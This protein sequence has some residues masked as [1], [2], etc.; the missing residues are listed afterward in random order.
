M[1]VEIP[2]SKLSVELVLVELP[3]DCLAAFTEE[4]VEGGVSTGLVFM[5]ESTEDPDDLAVILL[6]RG[7]EPVSFAFSRDTMDTPKRARVGAFDLV[8]LCGSLGR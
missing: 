1:I 5:G 4:L 8:M 2:T 7:E 3:P 6:R